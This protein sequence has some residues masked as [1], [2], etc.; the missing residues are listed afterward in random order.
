MPLCSSSEDIQI[1]AWSI[2]N[3][4]EGNKGMYNEIKQSLVAAFN[5]NDGLKE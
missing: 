2:S 4:I 3:D 5:K 1:E